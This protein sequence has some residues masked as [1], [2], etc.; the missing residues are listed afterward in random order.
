[1]H[2]TTNNQM[3]KNM[4]TTERT[5]PKNMKPWKKFHMLMT[6][7]SIDIYKRLILKME[8]AED[9]SEIWGDFVG[10]DLEEAYENPVF[11]RRYKLSDALLTVEELERQVRSEFQLVR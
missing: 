2:T 4:P 7:E 6:T 5:K 11:Q 3:N 1:M 10:E 9:K 8:V